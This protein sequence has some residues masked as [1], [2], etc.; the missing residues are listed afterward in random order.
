MFKIGEFVIHGNNG[1]CRVESVGPLAN[2]GMVDRQYYT[3]TPVYSGGGK[4]FSPV[5]NHKVIMR[6]I[7]TKAEAEDLLARAKGLPDLQVHDEK[8][9]ELVYKEAFYTGQCEA[10]IRIMKTIYSREQ[11]RNA[12]GKRATASDERYMH[13]AEDS[14]YGELAMSF[15]VTKEEAKEQFLQ[16][17]RA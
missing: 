5:D 13:L 3:L 11:Q 7:L 16:S 6:R 15:G 14:L 4:I 8:K 2:M 9:R 17:V 10:M 12:Q 1:V